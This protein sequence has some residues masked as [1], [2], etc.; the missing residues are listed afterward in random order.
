MNKTFKFDFPLIKVKP[1]TKFIKVLSLISP[2]KVLQNFRFSNEKPHI[3][4]S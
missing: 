4:S 2:S 1:I 3:I